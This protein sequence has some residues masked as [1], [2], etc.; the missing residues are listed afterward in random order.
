MVR[1]IAQ[2]S[3][4]GQ[5]MLPPGLAAA[6]VLDLM[7]TH[8]VLTLAQQALAGH[9]TTQQAF[10]L[11]NAVPKAEPYTAFFETETS[12]LLVSPTSGTLPPAGSPTQTDAQGTRNCAT[13]CTL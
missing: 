2:E 8:F 4:T 11:A 12:E 3:R 9:D 10:A 5:I 7:C 6:P 1:R 13:S